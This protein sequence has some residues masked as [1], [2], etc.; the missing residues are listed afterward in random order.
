MKP[1]F[2]V[3]LPVYNG[4]KYMH[5]AINSVLKQNYQNFE[6]VISDDKSLDNSFKIAKYYQ[7]K[8]KRVQLIQQ[9]INYQLGWWKGFNNWML[10]LKKSQ[11]EYVFFI[12]HDDILSKNY[13]FDLNKNL[14]KSTSLFFGS[15]VQIDK[16]NN[17]YN[18]PANNLTLDFTN[19][20]GFIRRLKFYF[21]PNIIKNI[22]L[23]VP[24]KRNIALKIF[25]KLYLLSKN[26][27]SNKAKNIFYE[28]FD[29]YYIFELLKYKKIK[30][31][32]K[33]IFYKRLRENN[34]KLY[35]TGSGRNKLK[36][37][38]KTIN[39]NLLFVYLSTFV[40]KIYIILFIPLVILI[41]RLHLIFFKINNYFK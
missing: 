34:K 24:V 11:G 3:L 4:S 38:I 21:L 28:H 22:L 13:L 37:L 12:G 7:K 40:E 1:K 23:F 41:D 14:D 36:N 15:I 20:K 26:F 33:P 10:A 39:F 27:K 2:S 31:F 25:R 18:H 8:D 19:P 29:T 30:S 9:N 5:K 16:S 6:L 35:V 17:I 32:N